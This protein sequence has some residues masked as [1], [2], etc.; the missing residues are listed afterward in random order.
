MRGLSNIVAVLGLIVISVAAVSI[1]YTLVTQYVS[2]SFKPSAE[3]AVSYAKLVFITDSENVGGTLYVTFK[4]EIGIGNSG[5]E[6]SGT[7]CVVTISPTTGTLSPTATELTNHCSQT[8]AIASGYRTYSFIL[9]VPRSVL[10]QLGC[11]G[12]Y[13][14]CPMS[15]DWHFAIYVRNPRTSSM[16]RAAVVKPVY[17][18]PT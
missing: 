10:D 6:T 14:A 3:I 9:R 8:L 7:V 2:Q 17:M 12:G 15:R 18:I 13:S 5:P 1:G 16:E 11:T 4:G